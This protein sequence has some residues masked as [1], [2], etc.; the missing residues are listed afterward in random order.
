MA[1]S[2]DTSSTALC[3]LKGQLRGLTACASIFEVLTLLSSA[4]RDLIGILGVLRFQRENPSLEV[5]EAVLVRRLA[6][7]SPRCAPIGRTCWPRRWVPP[8]EALRRAAVPQSPLQIAGCLLIGRRWRQVLSPRAPGWPVSNA[9]RA[10]RSRLDLCH[11]DIPG[12]PLI[13]GSDRSIEY[14]QT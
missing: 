1:S 7:K 11:G 6:F 10:N 3:S 8:I 13:P 14:S 12:F 5:L 2:Q 9:K 4:N